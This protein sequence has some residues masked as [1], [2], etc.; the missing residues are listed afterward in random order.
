MPFQPVF[1]DSNPTCSLCTSNVYNP[2]F[3]LNLA[4]PNSTVRTHKR[5][6]LENIPY[7]VNIKVALDSHFIQTEPFGYSESPIFYHFVDFQHV[8]SRKQKATVALKC[9]FMFKLEPQ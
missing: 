2:H 1:I 7:F 8:N 3:D 5:I 9:I 6:T 4:C